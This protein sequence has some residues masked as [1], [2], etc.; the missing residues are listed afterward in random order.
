[1][2]SAQR[3][4]RRRL[5]GVLL[6]FAIIAGC[7]V[8]PPTGVFRRP[9]PID[10]HNPQA[11]LNVALWSESRTALIFRESLRVKVR[12]SADVYCNLYAVNTSGDTL[13]LLANHPLPAN[14]TQ[15]LGS[16]GDPLY[17]RVHPPRGTETY[18]LVATRQ[19]LEW[20]QPADIRRRGPATRLTLKPAQ[21]TRRLQ[22]ALAARDPA[23]WNVAILERRVDTPRGAAQP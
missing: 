22:E 1:M 8:E 15:S 3:R 4:C 20:L 21:L 5:A 19:P 23:T 18:V 2:S 6:V 12:S 14:T 13:Q 16:P 10:F 17:Y 9:Q 7:A 11:G